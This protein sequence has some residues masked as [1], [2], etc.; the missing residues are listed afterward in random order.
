MSLTDGS[1]R[2]DGNIKFICVGRAVDRVI[3]ASLTV[4]RG[5][6]QDQ[7]HAAVRDVLS[8]PDFSGKVTAGA[9]YRLVGDVNVFNFTT[10]SENRVYIVI[11]SQK[12]PERLVF[13]MINDVVLKFK[14]EFG[15]PSL[16]CVSG[17]LDGK[18]K[19]LFQSLADEYDDPSKRDALSK[20]LISV[21]DVK[22]S[23]HKNIDSMIN[24]MDRAVVI[25]ESSKRLQDQAA[26]FDT[27]ARVLKRRELCRQYKTTA[28]IALAI[29]LLL[30]VVILAFRPWDY[31]APSSNNQSSGR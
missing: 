7:Y 16:T 9:R 2:R 15:A 17:A 14:A 18:A 27:Q 10:D 5:D 21:N 30:T 23:M 3:V 26:R 8:A 25:E 6:N 19:R 29:I 31:I 28:C 12:Y 11:T 1:M 22:T 24:N 4:Q 13:P 20:V